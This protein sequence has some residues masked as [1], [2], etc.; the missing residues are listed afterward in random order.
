[1]MEF[2]LFLRR[3]IRFIGDVLSAFNKNNNVPIS[4]IAT[5]DLVTHPEL[6]FNKNKKYLLISFA[7]SGNSPESS[8][9][10]ILAEELSKY[11]LLFLSSLVGD[12][13]GTTF[14]FNPEAT[15]KDCKPGSFT[16][17]VGRIIIYFNKNDNLKDQID[18]IHQ[19][20][21]ILM[22]IPAN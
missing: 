15:I 7:R 2:R 12:Y 17:N 13:A 5:T 11:H 1:M 18:L 19:M 22:N 21:K 10:I 9:A 20:V 4:S 6:F 14:I 16:L 3:D 8:Q